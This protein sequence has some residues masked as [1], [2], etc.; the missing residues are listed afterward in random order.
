MRKKNG[1]ET[2]LTMNRNYLLPTLPEGLEG[3]AELALDLRWS[4]NHAA[5][6]LWKHVDPELWSMTSNPWLM[7][8]TVKTNRLKA[9][10]TD[11]TFL[12]LMD[13]LMEGHREAI[14]Q[15]AWFQQTHPQST[16]KVAYFC[17]E[18]GLGEALPIYAGGLGILAGDY[19]KTA[20]DLGV[21]VVGVGLLYQQGYFRQTVDAHGDQTEF[22]PYNDPGQLPVMPVRD[23]NGEWLRIKIDLPGGVLWLRAWEAIVG[24]VKL[25]LLDSNDPINSP[26]D[27]GITSELY[28][29]GS[30]LRLQQ[31]IVLG[32]GGWRLLDA[33]GIQPEV[34]HLN[35]GHAALAVVERAR[36]FMVSEHQPFKVALAATRAGNIFTTHTPVEAGFDRFSPELVSRYLANYADQLG[37]GLGGLLALGRQD[38]SNSQEPFNMAFLA[39][40]GSGVVNGVSRLHGEVSRRIFQPLFPRWPKGEVP[41][42]HVTNGVHVPSWD[43]AT[44]DTTWTNAC[45][46]GRWLNTM[47]TIKEDLKKT[48]DESLWQ[49]RMEEA[50]QLI[51]YVR[52]RLGRQLARAGASMQLIKQSNQLLNPGVLTMGFARRF[53]AY[54]RP[55]LLL[56]DPD[57]LSRILNN[58]NRPVQ[59][60][61]AGKAHP[62]DEEGKAL[63]R[64]WWEYSLRSDVQNKVVFLSD[65]DMALAEQLVQ[66]VDLWINTPRRPWEACG[67]SGMKVLVNGGLNLSERD[68]WWAEAYRTEVGWAIGDGQEHGDDPNWNAQEAEETY[69]LLEEEI[70]PCFYERDGRGI[71]TAWTARMRTSM[72]ELTPRFST[73]RMLREYVDRLYVTAAQ[74][75]HKRSVDGANESV[76]LCRWRELLETHWQKLHFGR[77]SVQREGDEYIMMVEAYLDELDPKAVQVQLFAE[78]MGNGE[79]E[80]H[81]MNVA[82]AVGTANSYLYCARIPARRRAEDYTPRIV[83]YFDG[84]AVPLEARQI[85]WYES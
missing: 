26:A 23:Q 1:K 77:L 18:Y 4:W 22:Y 35:E 10:A 38:P 46:K 31:E 41:I 50:E 84:A 49:L 19:L 17:M 40:R 12:G 51:H 65:Y 13:E 67:T 25:Y 43:S 59:L 81:V 75:Y 47:D 15:K 71:P 83:P 70:I 85:L 42:T 52:A 34:C 11:S 32:I 45:G 69:R 63:V 5:D 73:N 6:K 3:L 2:I 21:P 7:L 74:N 48:T 39:M 8:Q 57:R 61:I 37:I 56:H 16:L 29:G 72:A 20:S 14:K 24:R 62:R 66:G 28:G 82:E 30:E 64:A 58:S 36:S 60:V 27:R 53:T 55:N 33:I 44:A 79:S 80:I 76:R 68:G 54:K 78:P 9:L